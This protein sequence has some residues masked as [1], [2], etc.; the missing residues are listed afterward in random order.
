MSRPSLAFLRPY[1]YRALG[2]VPK[3]EAARAYGAI[4][5]R[6][7]QTYAA[8]TYTGPHDVEKQKRLEQLRKV[9]PLGDYHPRLQH[10]AGLEHLSVRDFNT[11]YEAIR[12]TQ[13]EIISV[14]GTKIKMHML[15]KIDTVRKGTV[16]PAARFETDVPRYRARSTAVTSHGRFEQAGTVHQQSR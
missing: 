7:A 16:S 3:P 2:P 8:D 15:A 12:E 10:P 13:P 11:K 9:K 4:Q 5:R 1:L 14:F 6:L